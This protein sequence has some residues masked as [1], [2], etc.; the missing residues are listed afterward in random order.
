M[1]Y[2]KMLDRLYMLL[3]NKGAETDRLE[4]PKPDSMVQGKK[5][6][7][8]NYSEIMKVLRRE[9]KMFLKFLTKE[10]ATSAAVN[11]GRLVINGKFF[12]LQIIKLFE[13]FTKHFVTCPSCGK[14]DTKIVDQS[15]VKMLKCEACG[16]LSPLTKL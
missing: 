4:V 13:K 6:F 10:T 9:D 8:K 2:N 7:V 5:T 15:G 3:P 11:E 12:A 1:E 16:S 14:L